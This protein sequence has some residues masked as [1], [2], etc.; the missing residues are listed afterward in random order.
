MNSFRSASVMM[1]RALCR[2]ANPAAKCRMSSRA[3]PSDTYRIARLPWIPH[4]LLKA[5]SP[6]L[7]QRDS[8]FL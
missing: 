3:V 6:S 2:A 4:G 7:S 5:T 8:V 1:T